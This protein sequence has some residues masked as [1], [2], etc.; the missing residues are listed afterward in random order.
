MNVHFDVWQSE[1]SLVAGGAVERA[2]AALKAGGESL[3]EEEGKLWF[4][5]TAFGDDKDRVVLRDTVRGPTSPV[6]SP[7]TS[8]R[9][10]GLT[11]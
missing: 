8:R 10:T 7:T 4:R 9:W 3:Y 5:S 6:I 11:V 1:R 2:L